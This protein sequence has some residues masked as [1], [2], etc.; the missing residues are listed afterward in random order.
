MRKKRECKFTANLPVDA[1]SAYLKRSND[2]KVKSEYQR[3]RIQMGMANAYEK[4]VDRRFHA[5]D[6]TPC[7]SEEEA[8]MLLHPFSRLSGERYSW[9]AK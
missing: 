7:Q 4:R 5:Q 6:N 2:R 3:S 8:S 9:P 1:K